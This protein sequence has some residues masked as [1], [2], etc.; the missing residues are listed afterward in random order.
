MYKSK[1]YFKHKVIAQ[2]FIANPEQYNNV[3]HVNGDKT[4]N[5]IENL[6]WSY[7]K[8]SSL[9]LTTVAEV[10]KPAEVEWQLHKCF[11]K[12]EIQA[13]YPYRMRYVDTK[14]LLREETR[15]VVMVEFDLKMVPKHRLVAEHFIE[16]PE[17]KQFVVF[18]NGDKLDYHIEN[19]QWL[20]KQEQ[21]R[22]CRKKASSIECTYV[23]PEGLIDL[24]GITY[25]TSTFTNL[26]FDGETLWNFKNYTKQWHKFT[27]YRGSCNVKDDNSN[28]VHVSIKKL[29]AILNKKTLKES[30]IDKIKESSKVVELNEEISEKSEDISQA[31]NDDEEAEEPFDVQAFLDK[32]Y[33]ENYD[34]FNADDLD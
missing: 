12:I 28:P 13:E 22:I 20:S 16:N 30:V 1:T 32:R 29:T 9:S 18:K 17:H 15:D 8:R 7:G 19:L 5:R 25:G 6:R 14:F 2:Q 10:E 23:K 24:S 34:M 21:G 26:Y 3:L 11:T 4:D 27:V 33:G 31:H